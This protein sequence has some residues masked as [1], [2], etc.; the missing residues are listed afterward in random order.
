MSGSETGPSLA[1][2]TSTA[3]PAVS[4][5]LSRRPD[6]RAGGS[7]YGD[8]VL[9]RTD[10]LRTSSPASGARSLS[11]APIEVRRHGGLPAR[12]GETACGTLQLCSLCR[13]TERR[14]S[15]QGR[16]GHHASVEARRGSPFPRVV[17]TP[18]GLGC[19]SVGRGT[20]RLGWCKPMSIPECSATTLRVDEASG[21][22]GG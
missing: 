18:V 19:C 14:P 1:S 7:A 4:R 9:R 3:S 15:V 21:G 5:A 16:V 8:D 11:F 2:V 13:W 22:T 17:A 10:R 12:A 6:C 20:A